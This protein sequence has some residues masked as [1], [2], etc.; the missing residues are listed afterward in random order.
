MIEVVFKNMEKA[1]LSA[2]SSVFIVEHDDAKYVKDQI[3]DIY[4]DTDLTKF[5][6]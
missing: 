4:K 1:P 3:G 6:L 5:I 2:Q